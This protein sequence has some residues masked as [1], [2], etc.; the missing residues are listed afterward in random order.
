MK[1]H[2]SITKWPIHE[3]EAKRTNVVEFKPKD[4]YAKLNY[5]LDQTFESPFIL[6]VTMQCS[7]VNQR[8]H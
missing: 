8:P 1:N 6:R 3:N 2:T 4:T 5:P 7:A